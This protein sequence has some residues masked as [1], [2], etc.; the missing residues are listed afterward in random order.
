[1]STLTGIIT[2]KKGYNLVA[3]PET[4]GFSIVYKTQNKDGALRAFKSPNLSRCR[5]QK[6]Q[7]KLS[8]DFINEC[9]KL[10]ELNSA[11]QR[12]PHIIQIYEIE[13]STSPYYVE[14]DYI[15]GLPFDEFANSRFLR[16]KEVYRFIL[17]ISS[18]LAFCHNHFD[19]N[20]MHHCLIHNDLHAANIRYCKADGQFYLIDFGLSM[21]K[22]EAMRSSRRS[23][24]WCEFMPPERCLM[25]LTGDGNDEAL[26]AWDI[27]SFGCLIFLALT[28]EPPFS[29]N[30]YS[31]DLQ[32]C[33][34][35]TEVARHKPWE[36]IRDL[37]A[38]H[39]K[40]FYPDRPYADDCPE[41]LIN[42]VKKCMSQEAAGRYEDGECFMDAFNKHLKKATVPY[43][44]YAA[45]E[46]QRHVL[47]NR[48]GQLNKQYNS[49]ELDAALLR[50]D[51]KQ[52]HDLQLMEAFLVVIAFAI[53]G[54]A[55]WGEG[56][57][58]SG[59]I[60]LLSMLI[61]AITIVTVIGVSIY[62]YYVCKKK[63]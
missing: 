51:V 36:K 63:K 5:D 57:E 62:T 22:G 55:Y 9:R 39:Y 48:Y 21:N 34:M 25:E 16:I 26:P 35:H 33:Q 8:S 47:Q 20:G 11:K 24:G 17:E 58:E 37:R 30:E 61:A 19:A 6:E 31:N 14:M 32:I 27:Y 23:K 42:M 60:D 15:E 29:I 1:M 12:N 28:G 43:G 10:E 59:F 7:R 38:S 3:D 49:M 53:N 41:W 2:K 50:E 40:E 54:Y 52:V 4:G 56:S 13:T 45:L 18:A 44:E 46:E